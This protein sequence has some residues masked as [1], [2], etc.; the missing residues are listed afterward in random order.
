MPQISNKHT[1]A[2]YRDMGQ[3][4]YAFILWI[5]VDIFAMYIVTHSILIGQEWRTHICDRIEE[6]ALVMSNGGFMDFIPSTDEW[7]DDWHQQ[8]VICIPKYFMILITKF[9]QILQNMDR[10]CC[11]VA[12]SFMHMLNYANIGHMMH[13]E[14]WDC[15]D[16]TNIIIILMCKDSW[17]QINIKQQ[18]YSSFF[19]SIAV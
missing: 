19:F 15:N 4:K 6:F 17:F 10:L 13:T 16:M 14:N 12:H 5:S 3:Y 9:K 8:N 11:L 18:K 1:Q 2:L 7:F